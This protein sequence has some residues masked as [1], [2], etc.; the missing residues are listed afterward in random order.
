MPIGS[1]EHQARSRVRRIN[2]AAKMPLASA[3]LRNPRARLM[4]RYRVTASKVSKFGTQPL[5]VGAGVR[6]Y[7]DSPDNGPHGW[8]LRLV[9][10]FIYPSK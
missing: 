9:L 4:R 5:S 7:L 1:A 10:T 2:A 6:Y 3:K 8:G